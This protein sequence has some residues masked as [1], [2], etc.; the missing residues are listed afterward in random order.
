MTSWRCFVASGLMTLLTL[1]CS[2]EANPPGEYT[3]Q[4]VQESNVAQLL[5]E[6]Q[7]IQKVDSLFRQANNFFNAHNYSD[8]IAT[9]DRVLA[10]RPSFAEAWTNR[11]NVLTA[12]GNYKDAIASY[13]NAINVNPRLDEA[14]YNRGNVLS[15]LKRYKDAVTSYDKA[16]AIQPDKDEAWINRGIALTKL[17]RYQDAIIAYENVI[18]INPKKDIAYYNKACTYALQNN[19][20]LSIENLQQAIKLAPSKYKKLAKTDNDFLKIRQDKRFQ[21]LL[22]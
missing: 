13:D 9:Y 17:Q 22:D 20:E 11:G 7:T 14:W 3:Q 15:I 6:A 8:A 2:N 5:T 18:K 16:I 1:G 10:I 19:V 21:A 4:A 12:I